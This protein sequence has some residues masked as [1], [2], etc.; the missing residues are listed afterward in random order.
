MENNL[1]AIVAEAQAILEKVSSRADWE[2]AK[3]SISGP[4][5]TLTHTAK[6]IGS[7]A[8]KDRPAFGQALNLAKKRIE[9]LFK[10]SLDV[11]DRHADLKA[12]GEKVDPTLPSVPDLIG[13][14]HPLT[15]VRSCLLYTS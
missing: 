7:L 3:A 1:Q 15:N 8:K 9:E 4:N 13:R 6:Q 10:N 12:L 14:T 2:R 5:G 11:I